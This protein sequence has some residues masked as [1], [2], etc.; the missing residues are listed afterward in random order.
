MYKKF[1]IIRFERLYPLKATKLPL[2]AAMLFPF[3]HFMLNRPFSLCPCLAFSAPIFQKK[4]RRVQ[5]WLMFDN[6]RFRV[7]CFRFSWPFHPEFLYAPFFKENRRLFSF[8]LLCL[9]GRRL[10]ATFC[11]PF[12]PLSKAS[13]PSLFTR[14]SRRKCSVG[15]SRW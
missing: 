9:V 1:N 7:T 5:M 11:I 10:R 12:L 13:L 2:D 8:G 3:C 14:F 4:T 6:R 15:S